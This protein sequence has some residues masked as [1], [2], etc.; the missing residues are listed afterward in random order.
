MTSEV[1]GCEAIPTISFDLENDHH[2]IM[3]DAYA[4]VAPCLFLDIFRAKILLISCC[5]MVT[6]KPK[7]RTLDSDQDNTLVLEDG[8]HMKEV[9]WLH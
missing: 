6:V 5:I 1:I 4:V 9:V 7:S 3:A 8:T 2:F